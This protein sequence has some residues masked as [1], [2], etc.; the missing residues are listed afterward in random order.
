M[1]HSEAWETKKSPIRIYVPGNS[2]ISPNPLAEQ[3]SCLPAATPQHPPS[4]RKNPPPRQKQLQ[5]I[6]LRWRTIELETKKDQ[7]GP[8]LEDASLRIICEDVGAD[9]PPLPH[10]RHKPLNEQQLH[11]KNPL[12][13]LETM[14]LR[15]LNREAGHRNRVF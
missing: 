11:P 1:P 7:I 5:I 8:R 6:T 15:T 9:T 10:F 4:E 2:D 12:R 3:T 14:G 13:P